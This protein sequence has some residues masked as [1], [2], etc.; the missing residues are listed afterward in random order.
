MADDTQTAVADRI[1]AVIFDLD[2]VLVDS[3]P[4]WRDGFRSALS[5]LADAA[6]A[7]DPAPDDEAL[8]EFEGGRVP[9]TIR[10]LTEHYLPSAEIDDARTAAAVDR[11]IATAIALLRETPRAIANNVD[12]AQE[13]ARAGTRL[14]VAS[15]SPVAFIEA[16]LDTLG[17]ADTV[18]VVESAFELEHAKPHPEV[19]ENTLRR[20]GVAPEHAVAIEDSRTGAAAAVAAGI[21]TLWV[22]EHLAHGA[23]EAAK[24]RVQGARITFLRRLSVIEINSIAE[25]SS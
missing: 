19:Y 4:Y 13:L 5:L 20:L 18:E 8:H 7:D 2:G 6:G 9:D 1:H 10:T 11:A 24:L 23:A 3:E 25:E 16:A 22:N 21:P 17:L 12:V 14:A 15:S